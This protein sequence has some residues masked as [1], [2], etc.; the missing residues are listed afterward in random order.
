MRM[1]ER[2]RT[3]DAGPLLGTWVKIPALETVELLARAGFDFVVIDLEHSPMTVETAY[4]AAV[5]A[6]GLGLH[7][8]VRV[9]DRGAAHVQPVLDA[10]VDGVLVPHVLDGADA[11]RV[12]RSMLFPPHGSRGLGVTSR[13]GGWGLDP[14]PE[15]LRRGD[16][17]TLRVPQLED[18][19]ALEDV[20][21]VLDVPGVN[22]VFLGM[23]DLTVS[24]GLGADDPMLAGL[25][26]RL[27]AAAAGRGTPVG[28]A[29][30]TA[31]A[32]RA[33]ADRGFAFVMVGN[34]AHI[35]GAA[36]ADLCTD[37]RG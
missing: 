32:A 31:P 35:F 10:G 30:R 9:P 36:A 20:E 5:V 23:G 8:L 15:Y 14:T 21:A 24:T 7:A 27:L 3:R 4:R 22:A 18:L 26:D 33:A 16:D 2:L 6:Q 13:A 34:D 28:T 25:T 37:A 19:S 29:V 17:D 1:I 11:D 12:V